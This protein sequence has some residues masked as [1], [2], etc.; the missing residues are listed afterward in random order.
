MKTFVIN[1]SASCCSEKHKDKIL[2]K[3][4]FSIQWKRRMIY[5]VKLWKHLCMTFVLH[6]RLHLFR[7]LVWG[8]DHNVGRY[9]LIDPHSAEALKSLSHLRSIKKMQPLSH[10]VW[11]HWCQMLLVLA[12]EVN[13]LTQLLFLNILKIRLGSYGSQSSVSVNNEWNYSLVLTQIY[14]M[15]TKDLEYTK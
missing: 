10:Q 8:K 1:N 5:T 7:S 2:E 9:S 14:R 6:L 3:F 12:F 11:R 15:A 4:C 13:K